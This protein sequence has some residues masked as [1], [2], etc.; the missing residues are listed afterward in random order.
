MVR[1]LT[2][3]VVLI[4]GLLVTV[5][6]GASNAP[7]EPPPSGDD[8]GAAPRTRPKIKDMEGRR[9]RFPPN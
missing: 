3:T 5:G 9:P 1:H 7:S 4:L 8:G 2:L 6:C